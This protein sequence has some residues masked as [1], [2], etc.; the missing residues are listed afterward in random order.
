FVAESAT[1]NSQTFALAAQSNVLKDVKDPR[2]T[3][4]RQVVQDGAIGAAAG[5]LIG[6]FT[7]DRKIEVEEVLAGGAVGATVG[8]VTAPRVV[9][10]DP[11][12]PIALKLTRDFAAR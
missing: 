9:V 4:T 3:G 8:N 6:G 10:I 7:G 12:R 1:I 2:Q 11:E 5:A